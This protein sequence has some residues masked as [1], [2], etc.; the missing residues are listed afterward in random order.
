M[1]RKTETALPEDTRA[2]YTASRVKPVPN[3]PKTPNHV[4][5]VDDETW[6]EYGSVCEDEGTTRSA[7]LRAYMLRRIQRRKR[8][9]PAGDGA[10]TGS[11]D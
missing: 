6:R 7:D 5:R 2:A 8:R 3:Q 4:F 9:Q 10:D 1:H 11:G